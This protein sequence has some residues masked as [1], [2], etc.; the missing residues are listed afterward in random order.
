MDAFTAVFS[1]VLSSATSTSEAPRNEEGP[2]A[3]YKIPYLCV[4][5]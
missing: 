4:I 3:N 5:A 2:G 1:A